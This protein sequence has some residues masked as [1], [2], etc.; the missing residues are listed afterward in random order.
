MRKI[1]LEELKKFKNQTNITISENDSGIKVNIHNNSDLIG[2]IFLEK[3]GVNTFTIIDAVIDD[4]FKGY[5][6]Y[7]KSLIDLIYLKPKIR[8]NSVFR[9][10]KAERSWKLLLR[11]LPNDIGFN[12]ERYPAE[13]TVLYTIFKK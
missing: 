9:S 3:E 6:I 8:I 12:K 13:K 2:N 5:G 7:Q 10:E 4:N 11:N 1:I